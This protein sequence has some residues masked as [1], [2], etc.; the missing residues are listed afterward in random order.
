MAAPAATPGTP[1]S[2]D[3]PAPSSEGPFQVYS[4]SGGRG[5]AVLFGWVGSTPR[6]LRGYAS[7]LLALGLAKVYTVTAPTTHVFLSPGALR[8]LG[9][10]ALD[11]LQVR[12]PRTPQP[13]PAGFLRAPPLSP[14]TRG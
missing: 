10:R 6:L 9:E 5:V 2:P 12:A 7:L 14:C 13:S 4:S 1:A 3:T 8:R 11:I